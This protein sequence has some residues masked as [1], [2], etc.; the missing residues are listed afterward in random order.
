MSTRK[1]LNSMWYDLNIDEDKKL[2]ELT[3]DIWKEL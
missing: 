3:K 2:E 1:W